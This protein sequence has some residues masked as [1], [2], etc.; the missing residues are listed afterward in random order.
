MTG[1]TRPTLATIAESAGVSVATVSKVLNNRR[2]VAEGTRAR[3]R[4]LLDEHDYPTASRHRPDPTRSVELLC[5]HLHSAFTG[6]VVQGVLNAAV[7]L[8]VVVAMSTR[9][10][11][12]TRRPEDATAWARRLVGEGRTGV[13][14]VTGEMTRA[15]VGALRKAGLPVVLVDPVDPQT[16][17][18]PSIGST[19]F[20]G[21]L[22]AGQHLLALGH[23]R[24]GYVGGALRA[25]CNA[26]RVGG[27]RAALEAEGHALLPDLVT[28]GQV[29]DFET[30]LRGGVRLLDRDD[31]PTAVFAGSDEVALGVIEA[32][33]R[34]GLRVPEDLSVL[35]FDD[36]PLAMTASPPLTTVRQPLLEMGSLGL[37]TLLRLVDGH[38]VDAPHV[39]LATRLVVRASTAAPR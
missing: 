9:E 7:E 10:S 14:G 37:R 19:N 22:S 24:I 32:A 3:V 31:R 26:A 38:E 8:G 30:G 15:Q 35:G 29:F 18:A 11:E 4:V 12:A 5:D 6:Q 23:H 34:Q 2:D 13:V 28:G 39:A 27:L 25:A 33:R 16:S 36:V 17:G 1:S 21:G 20:T